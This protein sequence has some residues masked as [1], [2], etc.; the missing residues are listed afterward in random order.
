[1]D[2]PEL[3]WNAR[4]EKFRKDKRANALLEREPRKGWNLVKK[5]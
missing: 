5:I 4:K 1:M 3:F 2:E